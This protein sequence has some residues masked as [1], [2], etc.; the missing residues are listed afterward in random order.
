MLSEQAFDLQIRVGVSPVI[1]LHS[2]FQRVEGPPLQP[3]DSEELIEEERPR[4]VEGNGSCRS[5]WEAFTAIRCVLRFFKEFGDKQRPGKYSASRPSLQAMINISWLD[6][7]Q[8]SIPIK[9]P[10][11]TAR[12]R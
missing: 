12:V 6:H 9:R 8:Y 2:V 1:R 5:C 4:W 3:Q 10:V 7:E 11:V